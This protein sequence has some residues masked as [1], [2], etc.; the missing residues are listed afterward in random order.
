MSSPDKV[1]EQVK[2][3]RTRC[4]QCGPCQIKNDCGQCKHCLNKAVLKQSCIYRKCLYLRC[5]P[6]PNSDFLRAKGPGGPSPHRD[7]TDTT[8]IHTGRHEYYPSR[9]E[10]SDDSSSQNIDSSP[11][12]VENTPRQ[13]PEYHVPPSPIYVPQSPVYHTPH[14]PTTPTTP[15]TPQ[16]W[17]H[18]VQHNTNSN[19]NGFSR[20]AYD[21]SFIR[22]GPGYAVPSFAWDWQV[23]S[24]RASFNLNNQ[25][26]PAMLAGNNTATRDKVRNFLLSKPGGVPPYDINTGSTF[27]VP[28]VRDPLIGGQVVPDP[29]PPSPGVF[30]GRSNGVSPISGLAHSEGIPQEMTQEECLISVD[31]MPIQAFVQ[32]DGFNSIEITTLGEHDMMGA[33]VEESSA[34]KDKSQAGFHYHPGNAFNAK[35][36]N[37]IILRQDLGEEGEIQINLPPTGIMIENITFDDDMSKFAANTADILKVNDIYNQVS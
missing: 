16:A 30:I 36:A 25:G 21:N 18:G 26:G 27:Q 3:R 24:F 20:M 8:G 35:I 12:S 1:G 31:D 32:S 28:R 34:E 14:T 29:L 4:G 2:K 13:Q 15:V 6:N 9:R 17:G 5:K 22:H 19:Y 23:E 37:N 10:S 7:Q 33:S 11:A